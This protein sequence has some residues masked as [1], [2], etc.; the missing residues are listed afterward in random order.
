MRKLILIVVSLIMAAKAQAQKPNLVA[1]IEE[2]IS[3]RCVTCHNAE[4]RSGGLDLSQKASAFAHQGAVIPNSPEKSQVYLRV[5]NGTMP[6]NGKLSPQETSLVKAWIGAGATY[7]EGTIRVFTPA[8]KPLWSFQPVRKTAPHTSRFDALSTNPIDRFLFAKWQTAELKPSPPA[9]KLALLRRVTFDLTGLPPTLS[10][11]RAFLSD[12]SKS[13]YAKVVDRLLAS[14]AYGERWGRHW[15]DVVR[16]GE[17]H[18][19]EQNHLRPNAWR[20]RD[21]V[22]RAFNDDKPYNQFV[23]EQLA[24]DITGKGDPSIEVATGYLVAGPHDTVG[25]PDE[26]LTRQQRANDLDDMVATT[27]MTFL[28]LTV[29]CAKCHDHKFDPI[30]VRDYYRMA[31]V[32]SEV[33]HGDRELPQPPLSKEAQQRVDALQKSQGEVVSAIARLEAEISNTPQTDALKRRAPVMPQTNLEEFTVV[34]ARFV[35]FTILRTRDGSEPCIDELQIFGKDTKTN[36]ASSK[37]GAKASASSLLPNVAIHQI[38]H[39]NDDIYGNA[40]SWISAEPGKGWAQIELPTDHEIQRVV[41]GRDAQGAFTDRLAVDYEVSVSL[42]GKTWKV[43]ATG[44]DRAQTTN[45]AGLLLA[46]MS[47]DQRAKYQLLQEKKKQIQKEIEAADGRQ[48]A[49]IGQFAKPDPVYLLKRGDVMQRVEEVHPGALSQVRTV[50]SELQTASNPRRALAEWL[51]HPENPLTARVMVNRIWAHHFGRG[52]VGTPSDFGNNGERPSHP[53]LLDWLST[54]FVENGWKVKRMHRLIVTSYAYR[55]S[56]SAQPQNERKDADNR[57]L[58]RMPLR[59]LEAEAIRDSILATSGKLNRKM[60][61][62]SFRLF[63]YDVVNVA[64]YSTLE[65][66]GEETWRRC[67]Y[68]QPARGIRDELLGSFDCPDSSDRTAKRTSTTTAL[69]ALSLLNSAFI[70]QQSGFFA[71]RVQQEA[72]QTKTSVVEQA[73]LLA[74]SHLPQTSERSAAEAI[75]KSYGL[76][77]LCRVL[78]NTNEFLYY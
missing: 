68:Q 61:G 69:Q 43:V 25:S 36:L 57:Y 16:Y 5:A 52:I 37:R 39:L 78:L 38:A 44:A 77:G 26:Y 9:T 73:F 11:T 24:G 62:T 60:G 33:R 2:L 14:P 31:A 55:Q 6:P 18:G 13:A 10:E 3:K 72:R 67:I 4:K 70:Q 20:Y 42:D 17:S 75:V 47:P 49:Y 15:L 19:L 40:N 45:T 76:A 50:S 51:V 66:Q 28:G 12:T 71:E 65:D 63:K 35:R 21:Y 64:I 32:F 8:K 56:S 59:R 46:K 7:P 27:G 74:Y 23:T 58:W 1:Q 30:P 34:P 41:W 54:N 48:M 29:G 22:V 53:E